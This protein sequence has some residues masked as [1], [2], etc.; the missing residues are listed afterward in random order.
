M[1]NR[2]RYRAKQAAAL[3]VLAILMCANRAAAQTGP[4]GVPNGP[5]APDLII[6]QQLLASQIFAI[7]EKFTSKS[8][9]VVEGVVTKPGTQ[10]V[11][12]FNSSTPNIG[13]ADLFIGDP[14]QCPVLF[15]FSDCHQ[16]QHFTDYAAYRLWTTTGYA[17]WVATR[18][19]GAPTNSGINAQLL[20]AATASRD[21]ISGR[22]QGF[23]MV[24]SVRYVSGSG[25]AKYLSC[26]SNQGISIG[27]EDTY[28]PQLPDQFIQITG[29][30]EGDY[31]LENQ[32]NPNQ[33][34]PE[35]DYANNFAA[36]KIHYTPRHGSI[37]ASVEVIP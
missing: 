10:V 7:D 19:P 25:P 18:D 24:D 28:P 21:L 15:E 37:P 30:N 6:D 34:L 14:A 35:S 1:D 22:K 12:R 36:V 17:Y 13:Q 29:L 26:S 31:I 9:S 3:A 4:C 2:I 27:W 33:L 5:A 11:L 20:D 8:C 32:V 16:H 23:C